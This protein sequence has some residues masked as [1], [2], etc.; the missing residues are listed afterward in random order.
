[1]R[2]LMAELLRQKNDGV[3]EEIMRSADLTLHLIDGGVAKYEGNGL[4]RVGAGLVDVAIDHIEGFSVGEIEKPLVPVLST[5][6]QP[7]GVTRDGD[8]DN[9]SNS[10]VDVISPVAEADAEGKDADA[11][12]KGKDNKVLGAG[13]AKP[14]VSKPPLDF[15]K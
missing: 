6:E 11:E 12:G 1:M 8:C 2:A 14:P 3:I 15:T 10:S 9:H 5:E 13:G 7:N 4:M